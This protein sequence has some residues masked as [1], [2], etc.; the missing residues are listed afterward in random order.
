MVRHGYE[1]ARKVYREKEIGNP[2]LAQSP[3]WQP[4]PDPITTASDSSTR[5]SQE[6]SQATRLA[7]QLRKSGGRRVWSTMLNPKDWTSYLYVVIALLLFIYA[8]L[9]VYD[10]YRHSQLQATVI[11]AI[12]DGDPDIRQILNLV[13]I[14]P[15]AGWTAETVH[16]SPEPTVDDTDL[17]VNEVPAAYEG[18]EVLTYN[19]IIDLR[20]WRPSESIDRRGYIYYRDR[21]T[22]KLVDKDRDRHVTFALPVSPEEIEFRQQGSQIPA[23]IT[24]V[25]K[26]Y[27]EYGEE[28]TLYELKYDLTRV[29]VGES[30]TLVLEAIVRTGQPSSRRSLTL[31]AK[32]DLVST[33]MLFPADRPYRKYSLV[34][35][36]RDRSSSPE[37]MESRYAIDHPYGSLIGWS[38]VNPDVGM[39]YECRWTTE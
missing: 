4:I 11:E 32:S 29:P 7:R 28:R 27:D 6:P 39:V 22:I 12:E 21:F 23:L 2:E 20:R 25:T 38:V 18:L 34:R 37:P 16:E 1:V 30:V 31:R 5:R 19:R 9:K 36:P 3:P 33:W 13:H 14:D 35:Y 26:P 17:P 15:A 10:L 24:R 8:P